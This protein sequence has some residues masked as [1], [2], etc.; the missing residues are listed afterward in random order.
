M[1]C[2]E[3]TLCAHMTVNN[4][5]FGHESYSDSIKRYQDV[6]SARLIKR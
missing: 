1:V 4:I 6:N 2:A 5:G 3:C